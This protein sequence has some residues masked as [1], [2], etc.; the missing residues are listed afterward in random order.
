MKTVTAIAL[1]LVSTSVY[2]DPWVD[3]AGDVTSPNA[4][5]VAGAFSVSDNE[6]DLRLRFRD[7]PFPTTHT[8]AIT[9]C[10]DLD[11]NPAT[12]SV[13]SQAPQRLGADAAITI[14]GGLGAL[15][16]CNLNVSLL[17]AWPPT[18]IDAAESLWFDPSTNTLR[19]AFSRELLPDDG[20]FNYI[21][22]SNFGGSFGANEWVPSTY[23]FSAPGGFLTSQQGP[24]PAFAGQ[25]ACE[26]I[27]VDMDI[28]P[29]S[30]AN[31]INLCSGGSTPVAIFSSNEFDA[32]Q[33][34][35]GSLTLADAQV[36]V[37][38][39]SDKLLCHLDDINFDGRQDL[40]CQ[41]HTV[42]L[43]LDM[44]VDTTAELNGRLS[45]GRAIV[46]RDAVNIVKECN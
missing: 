23:N 16:T 43:A 44:D 17:Q 3:A 41:F 32:A 25:R 30:E 22:T 31:S 5:I 19:L 14:D 39:K 15:Q 37:V 24:L 18:I 45:N 11:Q 6:V 27:P 34:E 12:G 28:M 8:Q 2:S 13:C 35:P 42:D 20:V 1:T 46:G 4:D 38:G 29:G 7:V 21:V 36:R 40:L 26:A 9:V 10:L 33:I